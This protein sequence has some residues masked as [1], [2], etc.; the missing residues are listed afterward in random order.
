MSVINGVHLGHKLGVVHVQIEHD[1]QSKPTLTS[2]A[3]AMPL[4]MAAR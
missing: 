1:K 2:L 4:V 3:V